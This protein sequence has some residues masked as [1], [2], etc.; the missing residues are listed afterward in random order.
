MVKVMFLIPPPL[1]FVSQN[2]LIKFVKLF[3]YG[4]NLIADVNYSCIRAFL[5]ICHIM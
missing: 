2:T 1:Q 3:V 5:K 4:M